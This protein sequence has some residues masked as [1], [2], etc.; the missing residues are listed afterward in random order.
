[1]VYMCSNWGGEDSEKK[2]KA[3]LAICMSEGRS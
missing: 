1:M 2:N 3:D